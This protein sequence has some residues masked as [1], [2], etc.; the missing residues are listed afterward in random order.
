VYVDKRYCTLDKALEFTGLSKEN[1]PRLLSDHGSCYIS[2]VFKSFLK[3]KGIKPINGKPMHPHTQG[4]IERYHRI[5]KNVIKLD[6][7]YSPEDLEK[8]I[9]EFVHYYNHE[10]YHES[11]NNLTPADVYFGR[12]KKKLKERRKTKEK[13]FEERRKYYIFRKLEWLY[14]KI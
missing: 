11:L 9:A 13:T 2:E 8:A 6:N 4:R 7:Y 10:R 3:G 5:M 14:E 12:D 1:A